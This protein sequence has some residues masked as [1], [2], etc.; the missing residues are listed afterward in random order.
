MLDDAPSPFL[1]SMDPDM[2][3]A[4]SSGNNDQIIYTESK[5]GEGATGPYTYKALILMLNL[6]SNLAVFPH[7]FPN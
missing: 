1:D 7:G 6:L 4:G 5:Y 3:R 2:R